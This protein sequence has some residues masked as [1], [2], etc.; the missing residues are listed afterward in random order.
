M[1][2]GRNSSFRVVYILA[3]IGSLLIVGWLYL[4]PDLRGWDGADEND[5]TVIVASLPGKPNFTLEDCLPGTVYPYDQPTMEEYDGTA[6]ATVLVCRSRSSALA[7][8]LSYLALVSALILFLRSR[9]K[10]A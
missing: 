9:S 7:V 5:P 8:I 3:A 2:S 4:M 6:T 1:A 10:R